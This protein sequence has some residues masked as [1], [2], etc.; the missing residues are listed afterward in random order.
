MCSSINDRRACRAAF[1]PHIEVALAEPGHL[2]TKSPVGTSSRL[3]SSLRPPYWGSAR[4]ACLRRSYW[5]R[6][7]RP[8]RATHKNEK[9]KIQKWKIGSKMKNE[10]FKNS[11]FEK[12]SKFKN[13]KW[14]SLFLK[15][16]TWG[17]HFWFL[18]FLNF[19]SL[20]LLKN[21]YN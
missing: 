6:A 5:S 11:I 2:R 1:G 13:E 19:R 17:L 7:C 8:A 16:K 18:F 4:R 12:F 15:S 14:E 10:K 20:N 9:W 3:P 21:D